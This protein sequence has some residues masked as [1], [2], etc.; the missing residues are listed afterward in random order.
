MYTKNDLFAQLRAMGAPRDHVVMM[1]VSLRLVG[2]VEGGAEG[3]LDALVE[4]FTDEGGL[5]CIP[6]HTWDNLGFDKFTLDLTK[7]E[8][9]LGAFSVVA[10]KD[11]RGVRS[12]NPSHSV[13]VFGEKDKALAL[14]DGEAWVKTPTAKDGFYARLYDEDAYILLAGVGQNKNTYLHA[15]DEIL[16]TKNRMGGDP[17]EVSVRRASGEIVNGEMTLFNYEGDYIDDICLR[18]TKYDLPFRYY[19]CVTDGFLGD[20]PAQLC[21]AK[22]M[23]DVMKLLYER[24]PHDPLSDEIP[25]PPKYYV[26]K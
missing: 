20:A 23:F 18:F 7:C 13:V 2:E 5:L 3:L 6:T 16:G 8:S 9:N 26:K 4:Y 15:V 19:G 24:C 11:G 10:L 21:S 22:G 1:H 14:V 17:Y 25:I 12:E